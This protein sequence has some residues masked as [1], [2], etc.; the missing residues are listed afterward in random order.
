MKRYLIL[1]FIA[2]FSV[3]AEGKSFCIERAHTLT[4]DVDTALAPVVRT[5]Y[6]ILCKDIRAVFDSGLEVSTLNPDVVATI[7]ATLPSQGFCLMVDKSGVLHITGADSHGLAYGMLELSRLVGV[8]PW[9][10]WADVLPRPMNK[11]TLQANFRSSQSPS[12][13]YRGIFINDE[14][15]G[16]NPWSTSTSRLGE[17]YGLSN[18]KLPKGIVSPQTNARIFE[19]LLR[20]RANYFWPAMHEVTRPFFLTEGNKEV[21]RQYGIYIGGSHCE[22]MACSTAVEWGVRGVGDYNY[23]N[24]Q[25][26]VKKFWTDRLKEVKDQEI[27]YTIGMRGVHDSGMQGVKSRADKLKWLQK[28]IDDQ[29]ELLRQYVNPNVE[30]IPQVF[31]PYKEVLDIYNDGLRVP[32]DVCLMWCD[33][34][35]GY[36]RHFPTGEERNRK[37]G[38]GVYYHVSYWGAPQ[39]YLWL[40][41]FSPSLLFE[42][43]EEAWDRGIQRIWVLNV[44]DLKPSEYQMELFLDM[45][46]DIDKAKQQWAALGKNPNAD[47]EHLKAFLNREFGKRIGNRLLPVMTKH[48]QLAYVRKP[49][50]MGG[51][52][53]YESNREEWYKITDMPWTAEYV[54]HRLDEYRQLENEVEKISKEIPSDRKDTYFHLVKYPVQAAAEMNKKFIYAQQARHSTS[55]EELWSKSDAAYD[56][57]ASLTRV[58][59]IGIGNNGKWNGIMD[60]KPRRLSVFNRVPREGQTPEP[61]QRAAVTYLIPSS[62]LAV[63]NGTDFNGYSSVAYGVGLEGN[64]VKLAEGHSASAN[65]SIAKPTDNVRL[66]VRLLPRFP[67]VENGTVKI[68]IS[69]DNNQETVLDFATV[70]HNEIWK[71][72]VIQNYAERSLPIQSISAGR[73]KMV[74][75]ALDDGVV[76][77]QVVVTQ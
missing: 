73:H 33:D 31:V 75:K 41:T 9:E 46:W 20:L 19:L 4:I 29:R 24:N 23:V 77:D 42:Q 39:D 1:L 10:W 22:P 12:V 64:A 45:A 70:Y 62:P 28:V 32:D 17:S 18:P 26:E 53:V 30:Q 37:G 60:M 55:G 11:F 74:V 76:L 43:M 38:N 49:E 15:W 25:S 69:L 68:S 44:G 5:S 21:A 59:N 6:E 67:I 36:I 2:I 57:I 50:F 35:Y 61:S 16:M 40:G 56:S 58:Y 54:Q 48:Y 27:L 71:Q 65:F 51:N 8:S 3:A 47:N 52:R 14:D 72:G 63:V 7:D 13:E 34:N 66:L